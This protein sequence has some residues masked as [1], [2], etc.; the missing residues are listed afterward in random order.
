[1]PGGDG[2]GPAG[3]G[4]MTG[5]GAGYCTG[6]SV[7]EFTS[8][9]AGRGFGRGF[10]R[11]IRGGRGWGGYRGVPYG[12][13]AYPYDAAYRVPNAPNA[14]PYGFNPGASPEQEADMLKGQATYLEDALK[15]IKKRITELE[16]ET[17]K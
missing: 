10:G 15:G 2:S 13:Y 17:E 3:M 1:M 12:A 9:M 14:L 6:Y 16:T 11:G 4:P 7:A 8:S 5:R